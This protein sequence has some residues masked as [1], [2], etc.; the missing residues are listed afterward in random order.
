MFEPALEALGTLLS[1]GH[2][3]QLLIGVLIGIVVGILPGLGGT[4]GMALLLP[5]VYGMEPASA[6]AVMIGLL[7]VLATADTFTSVLMGIPGSAGSQATVMDGFPM[8]KAGRARQALSAAF[9]AS[10]IGGLFGALALSGFVQIARPLVLAFGAPELLMLTVFG[11]SMVGVLSGGNWMRG[12]AACGLGLLIGNIGAA[13]ATGHMRMTFGSSYMSDGLPLVVLALGLFA[14]PEIVDLMARRGAIAERAAPLGS[15]WVAGMRDALRNWGLVLRSST[16]GCLVGAIPGLGGAVVDWIA[17]G[18]AV[19]IARDKSQFG[20]G[21]IRGVI[22]PEAANNAKEGGAL[23]PT[24]IFGI[25]GSGGTAVLLGG[26]IL[27]GIQPGPRMVTQE[28]DTVYLIIWSLALANVIGAAICVGITPLVSRLTEI[29]YAILAPA[30]ITIVMFGAFQ[31]TRNWGDLIAVVLIGTAAFVFKRMS[32]PRP[33]LLI[34]FVLANGAE[35][36]LYQSVQIYG[37]D[38]LGRPIVLG[39]IAATVVSVFFG[40]RARISPEAADGT[41]VVSVGQQVVLTAA[42]AAVGAIAIIDAWSIP[43]ISRMFPNVVGSCVIFFCVASLIP[44]LR[45]GREEGK[46]VT[47]PVMRGSD[48]RVLAWIAG[49]LVVTALIGFQA[50]LVVFMVAFLTIEARIGPVVACTFALAIAGLLSG[51][52][53]ALTI[54]FPAGVLNLGF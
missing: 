1:G 9:T 25:P 35:I 41:V 47:D 34:G 30:M 32:W 29:R 10:L 16:I 42:V 13:P 24:L 45:R 8:A 28:L 48:W 4:A 46:A 5:F 17:Y 49:L 38:W 36:Y 23:V 3:F 27:I 22:A 7:A 43:A 11:L 37:L 44:L 20:K 54:R 21:D 19:Q 53:Y 18:S 12:L 14:L 39:L 40:A 31:A 2:L 15:G 33:P 50:A 52:A 6:L 51:L 26:L